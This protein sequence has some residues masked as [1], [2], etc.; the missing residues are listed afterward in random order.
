MAY[1]DWVLKHKQK[2]TY[3]NCVKGRYYLYAA[4]SKRIPGTGKVNR[5]CDGYLGR[6][7]EADGL[8]PSRYKADRHI[9]VHEYGASAFLLG[10]CADLLVA[11]RAEPSADADSVLVAALLLVTHGAY[12][13]R[14][15]SRSHLSVVFPDVRLEGL[16]AERVSRAEND[17]RNRLGE[18]SATD[19]AVVLEDLPYVY[20]V[21]VDEKWCLVGLDDAVR[22]FLGRHGM[23]WRD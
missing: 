12:D 7:T 5:V 22:A 15:L 11:L 16:P 6:I 17:I 18:L 19:R 10:Y 21:R 9:V 8:I 4:H 20:K 13:A 14:A 23:D 3:V 1:P 2:G